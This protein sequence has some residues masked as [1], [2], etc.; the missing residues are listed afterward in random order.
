LTDLAQAVRGVREGKTVLAPSIV[1]RLAGRWQGAA[2][3]FLAE[4]T[5]RERAVL[6]GMPAG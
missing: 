5:D 2:S 4:M 3:G 1:S 6:S